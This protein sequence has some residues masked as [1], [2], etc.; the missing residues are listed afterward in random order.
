MSQKSTLE[1]NKSQRAPTSNLEKT[2]PIPTSLATIAAGRDYITTSEFAHGI[3]RAA[4]TIRKLLCQNGAAFGI[5]PVKFGNRLL[6]PVAQI[7]AL[8]NERAT[9]QVT[10]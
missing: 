9:G 5:R 7:A 4:Q 6:W 8:F 1:T 10:A 3:S 2:V